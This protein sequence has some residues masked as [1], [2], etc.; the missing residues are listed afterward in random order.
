[1][2]QIVC[3]GI[4]IFFIILGMADFV[5]LFILWS[6]KDK[7]DL[8]TTLV[9]PLT[10]D[11]CNSSAEIILRRAI[12]RVIWD[13]T[14]NKSN[15]ICLDCGMDDETKQICKLICKDYDFVEIYELED[16]D[17]DIILY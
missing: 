14:Y 13:N 7:D 15:L 2:M 1:M 17:S 3:M 10:E 16:L 12:A 6:L 5:R 8:N 4:L 9:I 11:K